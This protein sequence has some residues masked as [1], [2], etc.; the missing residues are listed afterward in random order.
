MLPILSLA[1]LTDSIQ[2]LNQVTIQ[3]EKSTASDKLIKVS[4]LDTSAI[5]KI[6]STTLAD[7]LIKEGALFV[8]SYGPGSLATLSIRGTTASQVGLLWNGFQINNP[9][10]GLYDLS[11]L[12]TFL[13]DDVTVQ[14]SGNGATLGS[15]AIGGGIQL[16]TTTENK[17]GLSI[18]L[19]SGVGSYGYFQE[20]IQL[21]ASNGHVAT[22]TRIYTQ[23]SVNNYPYIDPDGNKKNQTNAVF[24]QQG[25]SQDLSWVHRRSQLNFHGWYLQNDHKLPPIM[26]VPISKQE[27]KDESLRISGEWKQ[28]YLFSGFAIRSG[29]IVDKIRFTDGVANINSKSRAS[30]WQSAAEGTHLIEDNVLVTGQADWNHSMGTTDGY[31][32]EK[33]IDEFSYSFMFK[34]INNKKNLSISE[35]VRK[36]YHNGSALPL[37]LSTQSYW[38]INKILGFRFNW[39]DVYRLPTLNDRYWQPGGNLNLKP[40][41]GSEFSSSLIAEK[42]INYFTISIEEGIFY[43]KINDLIVWTPGDNGIY[44]ADNIHRIKSK[45]IETTFKTKYEKNK[46]RI[47]LNFTTQYNESV[48]I[49]SSSLYANAIGKQMMYTP[50]W[51]M[52]GIFELRYS[53]CSVHYYYN[54]TGERFTTPDHSSYLPMYSTTDIVFGYE[55]RVGKISLTATL[56]VNNI[57][58]ENYQV[59]AWRAMPGRN[60]QTGILLG[61]NK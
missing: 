36:C 31:K 61:F 11:L 56:S 17:S 30:S 53:C 52:K 43:S 12:P 41:Q 27:Q 3:S 20:G 22:K 33:Y 45:G 18:H 48:I 38:Q 16:R 35:T 42:K 55:K 49:Q 4:T 2:W 24:N 8:K 59:I 5:A 1:Q 19:L 6:T 37:L 15:G 9:S 21:A 10:L 14:Y 7:Q 57:Y 26:L 13:L 51:L 54:Q 46:I 40:E 29:Y 28:Q 25:I 23:N 58:N 32:T 34:F 39:S 44:Y 50:R 60:Y 47:A